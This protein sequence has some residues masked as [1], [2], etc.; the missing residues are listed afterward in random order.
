MTGGQTSHLHH[1]P[2]AAPPHFA[3]TVT[4][5]TTLAHTLALLLPKKPHPHKPCASPS[6][7]FVFST[8]MF[9]YFVCI[10]YGG[11]AC[12]CS[13]SGSQSFFSA[14]HMGA[15]IRKFL[16]FERTVVALVK[17]TE[18]QRNFQFF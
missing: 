7:Q 4:M 8:L 12:A 18:K 11:C 15:L 13:P 5:E 14:R 10:V 1:L 16:P 17:Q 3:P 2:P 9:V 6:P